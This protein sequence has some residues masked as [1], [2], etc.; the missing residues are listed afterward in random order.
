MKCGTPEEDAVL[1]WFCQEAQRLVGAKRVLLFG[2]R[3][4]GDAGDR[5]DFDLAVEA[6]RPEG[7]PEFHALLEDNPITLLSFDVIDLA[8][9]KEDFRKRILAEARELPITP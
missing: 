6:A 8:N 2:S 1:R 4:R 7:F 9:V 5:S 3:A